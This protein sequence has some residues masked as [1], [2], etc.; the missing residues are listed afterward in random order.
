MACEKHR[1]HVDRERGY[2]REYDRDRPRGWEQD[3][4]GHP[5]ANR[6][7]AQPWH[8]EWSPKPAAPSPDAG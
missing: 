2:D 4:G 5:D 3:R 6:L 1:E 8:W 7:M